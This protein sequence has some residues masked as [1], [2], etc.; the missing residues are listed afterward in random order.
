MPYGTNHVIAQRL[1]RSDLPQ[2][3]SGGKGLELQLIINSQDLTH[4]ANLIELHKTFKRGVGSETFQGGECTHMPGGQCAP[5][6]RGQ[7]V[8]HSETF[9]TLPVYLP[10]WLFIC[11]RYST[12][13]PVN[14]SKVLS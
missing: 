2:Q 11:T 1:E 8:L 6:P 4:H 5:T 13:Y 3:P 12:L 10:I 14:M 9:Q 7:K